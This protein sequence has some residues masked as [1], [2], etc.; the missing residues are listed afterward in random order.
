MEV[1][2]DDKF[3]VLID[4]LQRRGG[5]KRFPFQSSRV[6]LIFTNLSR[7][8]WKKVTSKQLINHFQG[9]Q[10]LSNKSFLAFHMAEFGKNSYM[11]VQWSAAYQDLSELL[12]TAL[13][14]SLLGVVYTKL[15]S[16]DETFH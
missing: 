12:A 8:D 13:F 1:F 4:E 3:D 16:S 2:V 9:S 15:S 7:V 10:H 14:C 6:R 11:P 5:W